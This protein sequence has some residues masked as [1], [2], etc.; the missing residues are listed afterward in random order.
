MEV[1]HPNPNPNPPSTLVHFCTHFAAVRIFE[2]YHWNN[3]YELYA[4][5][6]TYYRRVDGIMGGYNGMRYLF[7]YKCP[8]CGG[9]LVYYRDTPEWGEPVLRAW[10]VD[11]YDF[12]QYFVRRYD[13]LPAY[14]TGVEKGGV[15]YSRSRMYGNS[16]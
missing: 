7:V 4:S 15:I 13:S 2:R 5:S 12:E 8:H 3:A 9:I 11:V 14:M 6:T 1:Q 16:N 10:Y